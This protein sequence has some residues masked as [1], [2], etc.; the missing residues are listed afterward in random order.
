MSYILTLD[1]GIGTHPEKSADRKPTW[2]GL[3]LFK[4]DTSVDNGHKLTGEDTSLVFII[5]T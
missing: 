3:S 4:L 1:D 2:L 5:D